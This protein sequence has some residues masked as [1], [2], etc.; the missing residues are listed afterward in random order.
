MEV[1]E[2]MITATAESDLEGEDEPDGCQP[3]APKM[4]TPDCHSAPYESMNISQFQKVEAHEGS[5]FF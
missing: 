3:V 4:E 2:E 5:G 1:D